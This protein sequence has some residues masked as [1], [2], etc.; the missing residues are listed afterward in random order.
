MCYRYSANFSKSMNINE[1]EWISN[2]TVTKVKEQHFYCCCTFHNHN[3][4]SS[5]LYIRHI[6]IWV[7]NRHYPAVEGYSWH[8]SKI[9]ASGYIFR[10]DRIGNINFNFLDVGLSPRIPNTCEII[11]QIPSSCWPTLYHII[12]L[13]T[14]KNNH[15]APIR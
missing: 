8:R 11:W 1:N 10:F 5:I 13:H 14:D 9:A 3:L 4:G 7:Q 6:L 12:G 2:F 15:V